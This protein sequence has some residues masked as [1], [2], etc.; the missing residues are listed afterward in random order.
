MNEK[1]CRA[2]DLDLSKDKRGKCDFFRI[3]DS[4]ARPG[5]KLEFSNS[6]P[7]NKLETRNLGSLPSPCLFIAN[8]S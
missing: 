1:I 3:Q 7:G 5:T 4:L 6:S 8:L 2:I